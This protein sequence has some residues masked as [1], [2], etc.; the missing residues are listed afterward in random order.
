MTAMKVRVQLALQSH[1]GHAVR[2]FAQLFELWQF[3]SGPS[4][5][6]WVAQQPEGKGVALGRMYEWQECKASDSS[7]SLY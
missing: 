4:R 7:Y 1:K 5:A 3:I 2:V 6:F